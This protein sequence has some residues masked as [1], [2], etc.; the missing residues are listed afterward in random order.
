MLPRRWTGRARAPRLLPLLGLALVSC[1]RRTPVAAPGLDSVRVA[2][3]VADPLRDPSSTAGPKTILIIGGAAAVVEYPPI[4]N[5]SIRE[6]FDGRTETLARTLDATTAVVTVTFV[7]PRT[8]TGVDVTTGSMDVG[9]KV[10]LTVRGTSR[11]REFA[12]E[13][14]NQRPDPT[15]SLDFGGSHEA[16]QVRFE[17]RNLNGGDGHIHIR[18]IALR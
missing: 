18:E 4:D 8:L 2:H 17:I 6:V 13:F 5:G 14:R 1:G 7:M 16:T 11:P 10:L 12:G 3:P 15:V 9:L